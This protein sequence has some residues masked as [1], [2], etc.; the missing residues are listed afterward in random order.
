M[1]SDRVVLIVG[2]VSLG[3]VAAAVTQAHIHGA[4]ATHS[5]ITSHVPMGPIVDKKSA[6]SI[7]KAANVFLLTGQ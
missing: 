5:A 7:S 4:G 1:H 6:P 2:I 3:L